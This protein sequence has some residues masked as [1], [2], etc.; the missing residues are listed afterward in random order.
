MVLGK[1]E[2]SD[3]SIPVI[4]TTEEDSPADMKP[5]EG[6]KALA[7]VSTSGSRRSNEATRDPPLLLI[8][9]RG[10][11]QACQ[12][13][14]PACVLLPS[15][16]LRVMEKAQDVHECSTITFEWTLRGLKSLFDAR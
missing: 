9:V 4:R 8:I 2:C 6:G 13:L 10:Y 16:A 12:S 7:L 5:K 3:W 11:L 14:C 15:S 1:Q